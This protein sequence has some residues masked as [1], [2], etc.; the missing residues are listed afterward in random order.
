MKFVH[1]AD[2]H[3]DAPFT[4]L[5]G[6]NNLS[7]I[8]RL[9]QRKVFKKV[10]NYIKENSIKYLFISGDLYENEYIKKSTIVYINE[11]FKEILDTQ[12]FIS[13]GNH[14]PYIKNS[15][16]SEFDFSPN[17]HIFKGEFECVETKEANIY[18]MAFN[19]FYCKNV[20]LNKIDVLDN[21][22]P[23]I[24]V[25]HASLNSGA[26]EDQEYNP[27][28]ESK[29]ETL[30]MDYIA[31][32]HIHKLYYNEKKNQKI[33]Y[34][35]SLVSL[36]FDELGEHGMIV[37]EF[38]NNKLETNF[39]KLDETEFTEIE[40][41]VEKFNSKEDLIEHINELK[42]EENKLYKIILVGNRNFEINTTEILKL[43]DLS[44]ILK[45]KDNTKLNYNLD[46]IKKENTL[47]G[48]FVKEAL[49]KSKSDLYSKEEIEK[50]IE[51]GLNA[52]TEL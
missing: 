12:I 38:S 6:V 2:V 24:L 3:F 11:L 50:A 36:G 30:N 14:D 45:I 22:K 41:N 49:E 1:I 28:L 26:S 7:E 16:Y 13:P 5:A 10:I 44:N 40:Q 31:L 32:G 9:E 25:M 52:M 48:I 27:I 15:Y 23:N 8:R 39:V 4:S 47:R 17:V 51:I 20:E 21:G 34:P 18:G 37:G 46:E 19:D 35:G 42:L 43:V 33:V 29:L